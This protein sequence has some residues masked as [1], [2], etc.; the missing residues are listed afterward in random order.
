MSFRG[1][2][3]LSLVVLK[4][5]IDYWFLLGFSYHLY[6]FSHKWSLLWLLE[7]TSENANPGTKLPNGQRLTSHSGRDGE[8]RLQRTDT[9]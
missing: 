9:H 7:R 8:R 2:D 1:N 3:Y 6:C 5:C 4:I